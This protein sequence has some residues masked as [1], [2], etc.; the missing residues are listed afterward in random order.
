MVYA[1]VK[2]VMDGRKVHRTKKI[3]TCIVREVYYI[4]GRRRVNESEKG[5]DGNKQCISIAFFSNS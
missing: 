3:R 5:M 2:M 4:E 1:I